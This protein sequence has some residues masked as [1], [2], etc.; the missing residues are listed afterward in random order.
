MN[1]L[2]NKT[3]LFI[4]GFMGHPGEESFLRESSAFSKVIHFQIKEA[5]PEN[6]K[7]ELQDL[8]VSC[9]PDII[10]AYSLG[11]RLLISLLAEGLSYRGQ[12]FLES[13]SFLELKGEEA[14]QRSL[15]D[16]ERGERLQEDFLG[17]LKRWYRLPLWSFSAKEYHEMLALKENASL[18]VSLLAEIIANY[19]PGVFKAHKSLELIRSL[20]NVIYLAG[21]KDTKYSQ[22]AMSLEGKAFIAKNCGHN[23]HFQNPKWVLEIILKNH[24]GRQK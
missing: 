2:E 16:K 23:I 9:N 4:S 17:F 1:S 24:K 21:E 6:G 10:Y 22:M 5:S 13:V 11:G 15:L 18:D 7:K 14:K 3:V 12:I 8:I 19:S 20:D